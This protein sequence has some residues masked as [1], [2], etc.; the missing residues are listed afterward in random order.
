MSPRPLASTSDGARACPGSVLRVVV[1]LSGLLLACGPAQTVDAGDGGVDAIL[2]QGTPCRPTRI[3]GGSVPGTTLPAACRAAS[4]HACNP[5]DA[6]ACGAGGNGCDLGRDGVFR[7]FAAGAGE[8]GDA[9]DGLAGPACAPGLTCTAAGR[10]ARFCCADEDCSPPST[11]VPLGAMRGGDGHVGTCAL[12]DAPDGGSRVTSTAP[13]VGNHVGLFEGRGY[14]LGWTSWRDAL[15]REMSFFDACPKQGKYPVF[16]LSS[17][18]D[19]AGN[20]SA[21]DCIPGMQDGVGIL[22]YLQYF[23]WTG[24]KDPRWLET[25]R[26]L[27]DYLVDEALTPPGGAWPSVPRSSGI[28]GATPQPADCGREADMPYEIEPDKAA[29]AGY[30]LLRLADATSEPRYAQMALHV[31]RVLA[32]AQVP[33]DATHSPWPFRVDHRTGAGNGDVSGNVAFALRLFDGLIARGQCDLIEPRARLWAWIA[34]YQIPSAS[35]GDGQ[36]FAQFFEDMALT[37]NRTAWAPLHL[38]RYLLEAHD[39]IDPAWRDHVDALLDFVDAKF[40][41][42]HDG[43]PVCIEQDDD[44]KPFGGILSTYGATLALYARAT[45]DVAAKHRAFLALNLCLYGIDDDGCP[46]QAALVQGRGGWIQDTHLD[47]VHN[48]V[49]ALTA[50]PEWAD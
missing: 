9:C 25:A 15:E 6:H 22:S 1:V 4:S 48:F 26:A 45:G 8:E 11:C 3:D 24:R 47:K 12:G 19:D 43:Y 33:G 32:A 13:M 21:K 41:E 2:D 40:V 16:A 18:V 28:A 7:C 46:A 30:A 10:C 35:C 42:D 36:L 27:G 44:R 14:L 49:D 29:L 37:R 38:A 5:L 31:A 20:A 39:R 17:H 50:F 23:D 34:A